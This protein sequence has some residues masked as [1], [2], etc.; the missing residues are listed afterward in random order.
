M[1]TQGVRCYLPTGAMYVFPEIELPDG[2]IAAAQKAGKKPDVWYCLQL[3][4]AT[5]IC[6]VPGLIF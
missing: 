4:D 3:L 2:A 1:L 5:G 6:V